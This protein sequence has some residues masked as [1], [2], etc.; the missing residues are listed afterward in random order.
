VI[1]ISGAG[2]HRDGAAANGGITTK[3]IKT[4]SNANDMK[5]TAAAPVIS[6]K[7]PEVKTKRGKRWT[8]Y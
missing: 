7:P 3:T 6:G 8:A 2:W 1:L 4:K 5:N